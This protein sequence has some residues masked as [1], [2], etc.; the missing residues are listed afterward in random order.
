MARSVSKVMP[1]R[2]LL[3]AAIK[4]FWRQK[5]KLVGVTALVALPLAV[6][7]S[8]GGLDQD[9]TF[10]AYNS[11][12][13]IIM[14]VALIWMIVKLLNGKT[15]TIADAYYRGTVVLVRLFLLFVSYFFMAVPF[16]VG[17]LFY[18]RG[19]SG[20][21]I[22]ASGAEKLLLGTVWV[23]L[24]I[25][26]FW[27]LS[28]YIL[29]SYALVEQDLNPMAALRASAVRVK[30]QIFRV[31]GRLLFLVVFMLMAVV[32]PLVAIAAILR[33]GLPAAGQN[34]LQLLFVLVLLPIANLY[35][36]K[37]F[38]ALQYDPS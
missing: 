36:Y 14:N 33:G 38:R 25:P 27:L 29:A 24:A 8:I 10:R 22:A 16:L 9:S 37:L 5:T 19:V 35:L 34:V 7:S 21:T 11:F 1:A 15:P 4:D 23:A 28:R 18:I 17:A 2:K 26:S 30:K 6:L 13:T 32:V 3:T 31:G 12:L 20:T